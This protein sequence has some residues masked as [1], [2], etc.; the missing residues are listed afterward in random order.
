MKLVWHVTLTRDSAGRLDDPA[1]LWDAVESY[2][3]S[4]ARP[5]TEVEL[6]FL[7][8][9]AE[10]MKFAAVMMVNGV[11]VVEDIRARAAAGADGVLLAA[12]G[13]PGL[14]EARGAV[15]IP[16]VGSV[17]AG[18]AMSQFLGTRVGVITINGPYTQ[19]IGRNLH[20]Y[21]QTARL[22]QPNPVRSFD[23]SWDMVAETL[24]GNSERLVAAFLPVMDGLVND[25]ADVI[26][27]G[28]QIFGAL[29]AQIGYEP[30]PVPF[31]DGAAAGLKTLEALVD[32]QGS[33]GLRTTDA[34][35]SPLR[36]VPDEELDAAF[37]AL[38]A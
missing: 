5:G 6:G 36:R 10:A 2:A 26:V 21:E 14:L 32:L 38:H 9:T 16:V 15:D 13:E 37:A 11:V 23:L 4:I 34:P 25:G 8:R 33:V 20:R 18:M 17:E 22:V 28:G 29:L 19:I 12:T 27:G 31:I 7:D 1:P 35:S 24:A 3:A 30:G